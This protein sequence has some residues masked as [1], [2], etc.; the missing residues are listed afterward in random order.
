MKF[1]AIIPAR[2]ASTR[3]PGKPLALIGGKPM[4][5]RVYERAAEYFDD[6]V[7]ATDDTRIRDAVSAF[8]GRAV[9]TSESHSSGTERCAEALECVE[10]ET[11][12]KFDVVVNVQGD[13]PFL[14]AEHLTSVRAL[15]DNPQVEI[16]TLVKPFGADE[17]I[18][19]PTLP[20]VALG[21]GGRAL[22]FS[23]SAIPFLR[24]ED[25]QNWQ[26]K[27]LYYKHIGIYA[28]RAATLRR[29]VTLP[30]GALETA[31][32]LEQLRWL[33]NGLAIYAAVTQTETI[34]IDTPED[35]SRAEA[36]LR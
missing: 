15:F 17:D 24:G 36:F 16:G 35:L 23:R 14:S 6:C 21:H 1:I 32:S 27:H 30:P 31:E 12:K 33:E 5:Q 8:G 7:V 13:E 25:R 29:I 10:M 11:G 28:Y 26:S 19:N 4:I 22:F 18:F 20:K 9:M 3:F 34:A 2:Y